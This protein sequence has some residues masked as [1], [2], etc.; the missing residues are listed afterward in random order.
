MYRQKL[1]N[2]LNQRE[3]KKIKTLCRAADSDEKLFWKL[4]KGKPS[5]S[6]MSAFLVNGNLLTDKDMIHD[7]WT[8]HFEVLRTP[9]ENH[10]F[11]SD[12]LTS[13]ADTVHELFIS[14]SND[15]DGPLCEPLRYQEVAFVCSRL[16]SRIS[17]VQI[18]YEHIR[19]AG[20]LLWKLLFQLF[21]NF[22]TN[23]SACDSLKTDVLI[24]PFAFY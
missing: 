3:V 9:S 7:V 14:F 23:F 12:F 2:F 11:D 4:I 17:G 8:D 1:R 16:K 24:A 22:F 20:P 6:E 19:F 15:P 21:Q 13:A 5:S 18:D 10:N